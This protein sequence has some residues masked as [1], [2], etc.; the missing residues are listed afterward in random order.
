RELTERLLILAKRAKD[1][2]QLLQVCQALAI[3]TLC[4]GDP[5]ATREHMEQGLSLYDPQRHGAHTYLF[6]SDPA[7][8]CLAVGAI[9][10]WMLG[11]PD[12]AVER[13]REAVAV[14]RNSGHASTLALSLHF[15][16]ILRQY[17]RE[18]A[19]VQANA[20]EY[21]ALAADHGLSLWSAGASI[22]R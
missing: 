12:R 14:A 8:G 19:L 7:V 2:A 11:Y 3:T 4:L 9:A 13:S 1:R 18:G 17:R 20:E 15:G 21:A 10:L 16:A 22:M 5:T 6:G